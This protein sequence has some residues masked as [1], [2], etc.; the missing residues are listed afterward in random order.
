MLYLRVAYCYIFVLPTRYP[1]E[2]QPIGI[3]E[4][5]GNGMLIITTDHAGIPDIV[6]DGVNGIVVSGADLAVD[7]CDNLK[8]L[9]NSELLKI[10]NHNQEYCRQNFTENIYLSKME[11][12]FYSILR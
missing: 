7:V 6:M 4:A 10:I 11:T 2:G 12:T 8:K 3:L 5:M 1:N 9:S